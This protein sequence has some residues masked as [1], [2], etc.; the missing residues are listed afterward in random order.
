[1]IVPPSSKSGHVAIRRTS[2]HE[3]P[4]DDLGLSVLQE[5]QEWKPGMCPKLKPYK[6]R[7]RRPQG[8]LGRQLLLRPLWR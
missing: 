2:V 3:S 5:E 7:D 6:I 1:M 8:S 4:G